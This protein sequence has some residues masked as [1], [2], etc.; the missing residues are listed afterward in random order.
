MLRAG[1]HVA[2]ITPP[3]GA[4]MPGGYAPRPAQGAHDPLRVRAGVLLGDDAALAFVG[5]DAVSLKSEDVLHAREMAAEV[6]P[7]PAGSVIVAASH[8]HTG[9]PAND[10]LGVDSDPHYREEIARRIAGAI[11]EAARN[12]VPAEVA[13]LAGIADGLAWNRRWLIA[14]GSQET[15]VD[16]SREDVI[17]RAGP[18]DPQVLLLALKAVDGDFLGFIGNFT[19]HCTVSATPGVSA[20]YPGVWSDLMLRATGAPV[21]FLNGAMGDITQVNRELDLP[22][23]G[24]EGITRIG[25]KLTGESLK[26]LADATYDPAPVMGL[27]SETISVDFRHPDPEQLQRDRAMVASRQPGDYSP[28]MVFARDRVLLAEQIEREG[29]QACELICARVGDLAIA[30]GPGQMFCEFGLDCKARSPFAHTMYA[31]LANGNAGYVPTA[32]AIATGGYEPTLCRGSK[33]APEAGGQIVDAQVR[34]LEAL[35]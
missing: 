19:C 23:R 18:D 21:V 8:T 3:T 6:C 7:V 2:D 11:A 24:P 16:P 26:L 10:V 15:H 14:D 30:S 4:A 31:S 17:G 1:F 22:Q 25:R 27:A 34:L 5:V 12:A 20:D 28:E 32:V 9:G 29:E 33:L 13:P 35:A